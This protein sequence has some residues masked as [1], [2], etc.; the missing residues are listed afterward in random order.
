MNPNTQ[1]TVTATAEVTLD[2][3]T[4]QGI[5]STNTTDFRTLG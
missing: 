2:G 3:N 4:Y 5:T 1:Y